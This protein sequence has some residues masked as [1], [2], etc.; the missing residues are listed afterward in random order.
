MMNERFMLW[1]AEIPPTGA[2]PCGTLRAQNILVYE[3]YHLELGT[4]P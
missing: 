1:Y 2:V 4:E 3:Q